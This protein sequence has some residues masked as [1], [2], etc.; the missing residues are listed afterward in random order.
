VTAVVVAVTIIVVG[1]C[2]ATWYLRSVRGRSRS[3]VTDVDRFRRSL[4]AL[5]PEED[6]R[7]DGG[8]DTMDRRGS[9]GPR[10][11]T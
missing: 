5:R 6:G 9:G 2:V 11:P 4:D 8:D 3:V 1:G 10:P 7:D